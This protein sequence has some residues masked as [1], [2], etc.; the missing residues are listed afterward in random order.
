MLNPVAI[1]INVIIALIVYLG[2]SAFSPPLWAINEIEQAGCYYVSGIVLL[3]RG[4]GQA[5]SPVQFG[6]EAVVFLHASCKDES[7]VAEEG[8]VTFLQEVGPKSGHFEI[9]SRDKGLVPVAMM[10][11]SLELVTSPEKRG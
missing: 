4:R 1:C 2:R 6:S 5:L 3:R 7:V 10:P 11:T 9:G 8:S